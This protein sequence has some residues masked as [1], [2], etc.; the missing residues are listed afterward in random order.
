MIIYIRHDKKENKF[1][2]NGILEE[3]EG[4]IPLAN[5][6]IDLDNYP[7]LSSKLKEGKILYID[8]YNCYLGENRI[9][10]PYG[11]QEVFDSEYEC[12]NN[13]EVE[14]LV[15]IDK[16]IKEQKQVLSKLIKIGN[17]YQKQDHITK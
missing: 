11:E 2:M 15:N 14:M 12:H 5:K 9:E 10:G 8:S 7:Y 1:I 16:N 17:H 6:T 4:I 3:K 13:E